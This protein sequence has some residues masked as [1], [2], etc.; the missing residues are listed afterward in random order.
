REAG[1]HAQWQ[2]RLDAIE[3]YNRLDCVSTLRLR[4]WLAARGT[5]LGHPPAGAAADPPEEKP[6]D[7]APERDALALDLWAFA[8]ATTEG[9][10]TADA[11]ADDDGERDADRQAV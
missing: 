1:R 5:E 11:P 4:D 8:N 6:D 10:T 7:D 9:S 2:Q 3:D